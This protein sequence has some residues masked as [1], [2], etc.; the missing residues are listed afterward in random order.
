MARG[1]ST[2]SHYIPQPLSATGIPGAAT[3][4]LRMPFT[5]PKP[6]RECVA[7]MNC[8]T[9][10]RIRAM[11]K[12]GGVMV[13][14]RVRIM[15]AC[16]LPDP[17]ERRANRIVALS[18]N[19][20]HGAKGMARSARPPCP[21]P[22]GWWKRRTPRHWCVCRP[23]SWLCAAEPRAAGGEDRRLD[24]DCDSWREC[25]S[26]QGRRADD[27]TPADLTRA[28]LAQAAVTTPWHPLLLRLCWNRTANQWVQGWRG[29]ST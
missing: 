15:V 23:P 1:G 26:G 20:C 2:R 17:D 28:V 13:P 11:T 22:C 24:G 16:G 5:P 18:Y 12:A 3:R 7:A 8:V 10:D 4:L 25:A 19:A 27:L 6:H 21:P 9:H 29:R 14:D